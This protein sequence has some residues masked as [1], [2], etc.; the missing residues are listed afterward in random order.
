M[1]A[2]LLKRINLVFLSVL[3]SIAAHATHI[4]GGE[5][6]YTCL[7][8]DIY[9]VKLKL[10]RDCVTGMAPYD[11]PVSIGVFDG[12]NNLVTTLSI[13]F[14]GSTAV[15]ITSNIPCFNPSNIC[16]EQAEY[17][18]TVNLPPITGGYT[19]SYQR[20]C[21]SGAITNL[22]DPGNEGATFSAHIPDP[23]IAAA[24][25]S[26][27]FNYL[28]PQ[29]LCIGTSLSFD[30]SATDPDGD[31]LAYEFCPS[32][33]GASPVSPQPIPPAAPPYSSV[34]YAAPYSY[35]YPVSASPSFF[36]DPQTGMLT[37]TP[38]AAGEWIIT[39]CVR[40]YRNSVLVGQT[41][42]EL[43][44]YTSNCQP[45]TASAVLATVTDS[46]GPDITFNHSNNSL[47]TYLWDFGVSSS[48]TNTSTQVYPTYTY[49]ALGNYTVTL[50]LNPNTSCA[51]TASQVIHVAACLGIEEYAT[52]TVSIY[53]NPASGSF[54]IDRAELYKSIDVTIFDQYGRKVFSKGYGAGKEPLVIE[55]GLARGIYA[56]SIASEGKLYRSRLV[57]D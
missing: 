11:D 25:S 40:E 15:P 26:P 39:V 18:T 13:P 20:C 46:C 37:G 53:P 27:Y 57:I 33:T 48:S 52:G 54:S 42:R 28:F 2:S 14:P 55:P 35:G 45:M 1:M 50:V 5:L 8:N 47:D 23:S 43:L 56:V 9:M 41:S 22:S 12:S 4:I 6:T 24:N 49:P 34:A 29:V 38:D 31:S 32:L 17:T 7:G 36:I 3:L 44:I 30:H 51:D 19:L 10:Y 21:H 16:M